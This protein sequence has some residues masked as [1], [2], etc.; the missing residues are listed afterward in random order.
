MLSELEFAKRKVEQYLAA[1]PLA[2]K[3]LK[4][5][6]ASQAEIDRQVDIILDR[7]NRA[8][9]EVKRLEQKNDLS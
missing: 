8:K 9:R 6:G 5:D 2:I 3:W 1:M 4:E 7:I